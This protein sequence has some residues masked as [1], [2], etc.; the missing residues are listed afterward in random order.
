MDS[1]KIGKFIAK[2]RKEK[3]M[4]QNDLAQELYTDRSIV[5]KWERGLYIPKHDVILK[6]SNLFDVSVNEIYFGERQTEENKD[7]V[8]EVTINI[9]KD[10]KRKFK[11]FAL[12]SLIFI[13]ALIISFL[14][15]YFINNYNSI[16][17]Y[18]IS[19]ESDNFGIYNGIIV[20]SREKCY[21]QL[22]NIRNLSKRKIKNIE[23]Y[24]KDND[25]KNIIFSDT[26]TSK[27]LTNNFSHSESFS[28]SDLKYIKENLFLEIV[29][30]ENQKETLSLTVQKD[31]TNNNIFST[32]GKTISD[33]KIK[34]LDDNIPSYINKN[35][36]LNEKEEKYYLEESKNKK[37]IKQ[38]YYYNAR[39]YVVEEIE[40]DKVKYF[41][42]LYPDDI[43][44]ELDNDK[45][46][47]YI[48]SEGKCKDGECDQSIIDYFIDEYINKIKFE[49]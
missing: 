32:K 21:I 44:Y 23:L 10:N 9:I 4:T 8:S 28:Y 18:T 12:G 46:S 17:V 33:N 20:I 7:K 34:K 3:K 13:I 43:Y 24:Y 31:F 27:L 2:L 48:I 35:F 38:S 41:E 11:K 49:E 5:S 29:Y 42:Y 45:T 14:T 37:K 6:L 47:T 15:Y 40:Q 16:S 36:Q 1:E 30:D 39:L 19:G 26:D 25:K 22:G